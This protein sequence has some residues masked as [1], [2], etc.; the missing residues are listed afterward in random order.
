M[1]GFNALFD[2]G[3]D[4]SELIFLGGA[5]EFGE[6]VGIENVHTKLGGEGV[7]VGILNADVFHEETSP[8]ISSVCLVAHIAFKVDSGSSHDLAGI[9]HHVA[10]LLTESD[11]NA[12]LDLFEFGNPG[13]GP[14]HGDVYAA[15]AAVQ[16]HKGGGAGAGAAGVVGMKN[17]GRL[18]VVFEI[19]ISHVA[20]VVAVG[21]G[22]G[23][24][25][26]GFDNAGARCGSRKEFWIFRLKC[27]QNRPPTR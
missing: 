16:S 8:H 25:V 17:E 2:V 27:S 22:Q 14:A 3:A 1:S 20:S 23:N 26:I 4:T 7:A 21:I 10:A 24:V 5:G 6:A 19:F 13:S 11:L 12:A 18:Q 9:E 15:G